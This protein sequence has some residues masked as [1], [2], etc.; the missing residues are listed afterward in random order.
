MK[1]TKSRKA[2]VSETLRATV[3]RLLKEDDGGLSG[4]ETETSLDSQV[5]RY[6]GQYEAE[7]KTQKTEGLDFRMMTRRFLYEAG[8]DEEG[9][10]DDKPEDAAEASDVPAGEPSKLS[11]DDIDVE[12]FANDVVRL[13]DNYD[14]LLEVRSTLVRRA[15][16]FLGKAYSN[17]VVELFMKTLREEHGLVPG[18]SKEDA[19]NED[20]KAPAADRAG[21]GGG[22]GGPA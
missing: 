12:T 18:E 14:S 4:E 7:A 9:G 3:R 15:K 1:K 19:D 21:D 22:A 6:F 2:L 16:N 20:F 17:D 8:D 13:I 5:D 10:D 11:T